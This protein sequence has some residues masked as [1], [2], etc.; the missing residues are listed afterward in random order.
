MKY[1]LDNSGLTVEAAFDEADIRDIFLP[2]LRH[3]T[4]LRK[5]KGSRVLALL[6][7]P[8]AAGKSTLAALLQKLSEETPGVCPLTAIGMDGFHRRQDYLMSHTVLR[9]G[10][11]VTMASVKGAPETFDLDL[12]RAALA[13]VAAGEDCGWPK[14]DRNLHDPVDDALRVTGEVVLLEG[15]YLLLDAEG[16]RELRDFADY[17][18]GIVADPDML[19]QRLVARHLA[20]GKSESEALRKTEQ[21]DMV[22]VRLCLEH[23]LPADLRL[24]LGR[25]G[26]YEAVE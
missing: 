3:L 20:G 16:W 13:R 14:Y 6:A 18:V 9:D 21:S 24:R 23:S 12:M 10:K 1:T 11:S 7:A 22:N 4:A 17:T 8:P 19:R 25:D 2:L 15:N 26:R 5:A